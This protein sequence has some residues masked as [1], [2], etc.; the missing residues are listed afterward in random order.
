MVLKH[1]FFLIYPEPSDFERI[2]YCLPSENEFT[3]RHFKKGDF[4]KKF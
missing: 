2:G 4:V 1:F 3:K